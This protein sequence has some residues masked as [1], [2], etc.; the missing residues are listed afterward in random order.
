MVPNVGTPCPQAIPAQAVRDFGRRM[1]S[2][3]SDSLTSYGERCAASGCLSQVADDGPVPLCHDHE[4]L[5]FAHFLLRV[6]RHRSA[7]ADPGPEPQTPALRD[8][9]GFV[10][11]ARFGD[12]IKIGWS[13]TPS[14]RMTQLQPD[15]LLHVTPGTRRDERL[16]HMAFAHL[17]IPDKGREYFRA[18]PDLLRFIHLLRGHRPPHPLATQQAG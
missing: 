7:S 15:A 9:A 10:Y 8:R 12:A 1:L 13:R 14:R 16:L 6:Q 5:V 17:L 18:E 4:R 2:S 11:F 3:Y